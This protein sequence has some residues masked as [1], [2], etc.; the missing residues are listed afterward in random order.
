MANPPTGLKEKEISILPEKKVPAIMG[1]RWLTIYPI[2]ITGTT[3]RLSIRKKRYTFG[4]AVSQR[5][6]DIPNDRFG[7]IAYMEALSMGEVL[8]DVQ[9]LIESETFQS[10]FKTALDAIKI[11][12]INT[13]PPYD[14]STP[15]VGLPP[16]YQLSDTF[17]HL[18][19]SL[20][21]EHLYPSDFLT[22]SGNDKEQ[23]YDKIA[24]YR[25]SITFDSP[26]IQETFPL[27]QCKP[28]ID[29]VLP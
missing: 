6:R 29:V 25:M 8:D 4:V 20:D 1:Q 14:P 3:P 18:N 21:P 2:M 27:F 10:T 17:I 28:P 7:E 15:P 13:N 23:L 12:P 22:R 26:E 19:T 24:G 9:Y 16:R 5:I 11:L